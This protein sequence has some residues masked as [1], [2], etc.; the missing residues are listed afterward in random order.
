MGDL[1]WKTGL[2]SASLPQRRVIFNFDHQPAPNQD[3]IAHLGT[4]AFL[5]KASNVVLLGP[6]GTGKTHLAI[7]LAVKVAQTGHRIAFATAVAWVA[8]SRP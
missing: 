2:G 7:G 1:S 3:M 4:C 8:A 6:P 5:A